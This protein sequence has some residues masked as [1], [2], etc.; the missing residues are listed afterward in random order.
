MLEGAELCGPWHMGHGCKSM[1]RPGHL[2][3]PWQMRMGGRGR[4]RTGYRDLSTEG[5]TLVVSVGWVT[6]R[7]EEM[8]LPSV[9][10][11]ATNER[12]HEDGKCSTV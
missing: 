2:H 9:L 4:A 3:P 5:R 12:F 8:S 7:L 6:L 10:S 11:R 1:G